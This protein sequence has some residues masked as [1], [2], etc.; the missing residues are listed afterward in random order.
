MNSYKYYTKI[1][2][3]PFKKKAESSFMEGS[4]GND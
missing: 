1:R 2:I 3:S 4:K